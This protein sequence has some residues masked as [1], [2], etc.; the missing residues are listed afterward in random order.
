MANIP[1]ISGYV[2]PGTFARDRVISRGVSIPGGLRA[3]A[4]MGFG[5]ADVVL[6]SGALGGGQDGT[7][8]PSGADKNGRFFKIPNAPLQAG[9]TKIYL[10]GAELTLLEKAFGS[11]DDVAS[12]YQAQ[13]DIETGILGLQ[14]ATLA[15]QDG[16][17]Y[18]A[19]SSNVGDGLIQDGSVSELKELAILDQNAPEE[20]WTLRCTSV[21][22]DATGSNQ[23]GKAKFSLTGSESGQ[24]RDSNG[25]AYTF[26]DTF[27]EGTNA[28]VYQN[29]GLTES[30]VDGG[31]ILL[32]GFAG[33]AG[34]DD[35]GV[36]CLGVSS[37]DTQSKYV[38]IPLDAGSV[39][40]VT[41]NDLDDAF[42]DRMLVGDKLVSLVSSSEKAYGITKIIRQKSIDDIFTSVG[43]TVDHNGAGYV[44]LELDT[45]IDFDSTILTTVDNNIDLSSTSIGLDFTHASSAIIGDEF[46]IVA[47][48]AFVNSNTANVFDS[49]D[50]GKVL[51]TDGDVEGR[52]TVTAVTEP[53]TP[54]YGASSVIRV[55][56]YGDSETKFPDLTADKTG[57][58]YSLVETNGVLTIGI[59]GTSS[60][61]NTAFSVGDK[62]TINVSSNVLKK[63]DSLEVKTIPVS[64]LNDPETFV[65]A[66]DLFTK[67]GTVSRDNTLALGCQMAFE[68]GAPGIIAVQCKP[69]VPRKTDVVL[70]EE[71][72]TSTK[73]GG[74]QVDLNNV[75]A[76][77]LLF[78]IPE[79]KTEGYRKGRPDGD[80]SVLLF[81]IR[82]G[83]ETQIFPNKSTFYSVNQ[84]DDAGKTAFA[85][86]TSTYAFSYTVCESR[87]KEYGSR[88]DG[89]IITD[90]DGTTALFSSATFNFDSVHVGKKI[91]IKSLENAS[92]VKEDDSVEIDA[93]INNGVSSSSIVTIASVE[94][95]STV[96]LSGSLSGAVTATNIVF[97]VF[98]D[99]DTTNTSASL[100][101]NKTLFSSGTLKNGDGLKIKY[102]DQNDADFFDTNWFEAFEKLEAFDVQIIVPL[103]TQTISNIFQAAVTHCETMS[104][105]ANRKERVAMFGAING[106]TDQAI[107][108]NKLLAI[109]DIGVVEGI[110]G[111]DA[112][113]ILN[114]DVEDLQNFKLSDNYTSKRSIYMF[115]DQIVR[116]INGTNTIIDGFYMAAAAAG[117]LAGTFNVAI[118]LTNKT[119]IGFNILRDR[120]YSQNTLNQL[121]SVGATVVQPIAGG[122]RILA[123]RTTSTSGFIEDEEISIIFIRDRVK[124]VMRDS[125]LGFIG[126]VQDSATN[127][128]I[129]ARVT[130][131]LNALINQGLIE[132]FTNVS[133]ERDKVDA[134]QINVYFRFVPTF[135]INYVFIDIEVGIS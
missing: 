125:L 45:A 124:K 91:L 4:V 78:T 104:T 46:K 31:Y 56:K 101:L 106:V 16:K 132:S 74:L 128:I 6:I 109:E 69:S 20:T 86:S 33:R 50:I 88:D 43:N 18:K 44:I 98:D 79:V 135:P 13:L 41:G 2:Q 25:N 94:S 73:N 26:T 22:K 108:G 121:G 71:R 5:E 111:D 52:Y 57:L 85:Q 15:D 59:D 53:N 62:F 24:L 112:E 10:N 14:A 131:I 117:R 76:N 36:Y 105:I 49:N 120:T 114:D 107:I 58:A 68:N 12:G 60:S 17:L 3:L 119:L 29:T 95:D 72:N 9:R 63:Q 8:T 84:A 21:E 87:Y 116:N 66:A 134:R 37:S 35:A 27:K 122:G 80:T 75:E 67:H 129:Q 123:G 61:V 81:R 100:L 96:K 89:A 70:A 83:K 110:Q 115:P 118:P 28:I 32:D 39:D 130:T 47:T 126:T 93:T 82:D 1:G 97:T 65:E 19:S 40:S 7:S 102:I 51:L 92:G 55:H 90:T 48:D 38:A 11:S 42:I 64:F 113:E 54:R 127:A 99:S 34:S 133:V 30:T 103:P 77:D 23:K